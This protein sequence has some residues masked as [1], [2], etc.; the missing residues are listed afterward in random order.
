MLRSASLRPCRR[1]PYPNGTGPPLPFRYR[2]P[3]ES[4]PQRFGFK[5]DGMMSLLDD[6]R[7][8]FRVSIFGADGSLAASFLG[9]SHGFF[10]RQP[11][12]HAEHVRLV[13][14]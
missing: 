10:P 13:V 14:R 3:A 8:A 4:P 9:S 1:V 11:D 7:M 12:D 5:L 2:D 6:P